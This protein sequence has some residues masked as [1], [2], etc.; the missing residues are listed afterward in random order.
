MRKARC[1][2]NHQ[3]R[4][5][6]LRCDGHARGSGI[7]D[8]MPSRQSTATPHPFRVCRDPRVC[9]GIDGRRRGTGE[10]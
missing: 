10:D 7:G 8:R 1:G 2:G 4:R 6:G 5:T 3:R 9:L